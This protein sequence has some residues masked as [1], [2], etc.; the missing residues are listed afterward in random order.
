V[1]ETDFGMFNIFGHS[2]EKLGQQRRIFVQQYITETY[3]NICKT[4]T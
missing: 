1:S 2:P 4:K 3:F